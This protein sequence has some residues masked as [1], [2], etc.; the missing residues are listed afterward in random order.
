MFLQDI[1]RQA[2]E[3][4]VTKGACFGDPNAISLS[5]LWLS[6][7]PPDGS[8]TTSLTVIQLFTLLE[9]GCSR[10]MPITASLNRSM[11]H[12]RHIASMAQAFGTSRPIG[13]VAGIFRQ[14]SINIG[15]CS[16]ISG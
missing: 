8:P 13:L 2:K 15:T 12:P 5:Y 9:D 3:V 10:I 4:N 7:V 14:R 16:Q 11:I 6:Y 1:Y